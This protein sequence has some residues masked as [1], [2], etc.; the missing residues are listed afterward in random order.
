MRKN[1]C[2]DISGFLK[3]NFNGQSS[4]LDNIT[5]IQNLTKYID[6]HLEIEQLDDLL[7]EIIKNENAT[8]SFNSFIEV[9]NI[10]NDKKIVAK[11]NK[12]LSNQTIITLV[13]MF[14]EI[15]EK[16]VNINIT[17][18]YST[19]KLGDS[20]SMYLEEIGQYPLLNKREELILAQNYATGDKKAKQD[21]IN[22]N[23]RLV[24]PI[25]KNFTNSGLPIEDLIQEGNIGLLKA[26]EKF[27]YRKGYKFSTYATW[28][29]KQSIRRAITE[30]S[31]LIRLSVSQ[32]EE[33]N[34]Y[35][36]AVEKLSLTL[37]HI[38][39]DEEIAKFLNISTQK[40][41]KIK[42]YPVQIASLNESISGEHSDETMEFIKN[43]ENFEDKYLDSQLYYDLANI[44]EELN[45]SDS[46]KLVFKR[47]FFCDNPDTLTAIGAD[48]N[49]T[50][51][52]VRQIE[53]KVLE[54]LKVVLKAQEQYPKNWRKILEK[55]G[56]LKKR[57]IE[58]DPQEKLKKVEKPL[59]KFNNMQN[60]LIN[61][62][63][64]YF[65]IYSEAE[66]SWSICE[67]TQ[68]EQMILYNALLIKNNLTDNNL[69][70]KPE[71]I[72]NRFESILITKFII[73]EESL[74]IKKRNILIKTLKNLYKSLE[75]EKL[76]KVSTNELGGGINYGK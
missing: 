69:N 56:V 38:P 19:I 21:L 10:K 34:S 49:I 18:N 6:D 26:V 14:C 55:K 47:R 29:I 75:T 57:K 66:V 41:I 17:P 59:P 15:T 42:S 22:C 4:Q 32:L 3:N 25:A 50:H 33:Y 54:K 73:S 70:I 39:N 61:L 36:K 35:L 7:E 45:V 23:L 67:L 68:I 40:L 72:L 65:K 11:V 2:K 64:Q 5:R 51:E 62:L 60:K 53:K 1:I 74:K 43:N 44:L 13:N 71:V 9:I 20:V 37:V 16:T 12:A 8:S 63:L 46:A 52:G 28:W 24:I 76:N 30:K 48:L 27:D 31:R 58:I